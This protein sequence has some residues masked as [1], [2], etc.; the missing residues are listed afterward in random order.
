MYLETRK[1]Y[2]KPVS[3]SNEIN[4]LLHFPYGSLIGGEL[5]PHAENPAGARRQKD[6]T[7]AGSHQRV[8]KYHW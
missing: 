8:I 7:K 2:R 3:H 1:P 6:S 5:L 4:L